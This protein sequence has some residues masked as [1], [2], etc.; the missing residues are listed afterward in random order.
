MKKKWFKNFSLTFVELNNDKLQQIDTTINSH[1]T[2]TAYAR[3]F[4][5]ELDVAKNISKGIYLDVDAI[6]QK[7]ISKLYNQ[8]LDENIVGTVSDC[9]KLSENTSEAKLCTNKPS[10]NLQKNFNNPKE[11]IY[12]NSGML[13]IDFNKWRKHKITEKTIKLLQNIQ[14]RKDNIFFFT[15]KMVS[16]LFLLRRI[17][18]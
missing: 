3:I 7:D 13:L 14:K 18:I 11:H 15:I 6:Y 2:R 4:I 10:K 8:N 16:I 12:F 1:I 5:P 17:K 9:Y